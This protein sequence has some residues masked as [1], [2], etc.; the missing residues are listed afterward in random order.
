VQVG[1][2]LAA[3]VWKRVQVAANKE[4]KKPGAFVQEILERALAGKKEGEGDA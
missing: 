3:P 1:I 2:R 4:G